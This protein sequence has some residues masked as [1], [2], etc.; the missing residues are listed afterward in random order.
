MIVRLHPL[1][2]RAHLPPKA[3]RY[4]GH[5]CRHALSKKP[6]TEQ[7]FTDRSTLNNNCTP[8]TTQVAT[9]TPYQFPEYC[10]VL[11]A[12]DT[13]REA[14]RWTATSE[15]DD[16]FSTRLRNWTNPQGM[17]RCKYTNS[18]DLGA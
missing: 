18:K 14:L 3:R 11:C 9:G 7:A 13:S 1:R 15:A 5:N 8:A 16:K 17:T 2:S 4:N 10:V 12:S 6:A